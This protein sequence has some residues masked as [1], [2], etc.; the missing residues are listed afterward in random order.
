[1][2]TKADYSTEEWKAIAG[3]PMVAGLLITSADPGNP[4]GIAQQA[5]AVGN[6][7]KQSTLGDA[8]DIVKAVVEGVKSGNGRP[9]LP[10]IPAGDWSETNGALMTAIKSAVR[11]VERKS[12]SEVEAYKTWLAVVAAKVSWATKEVGVRGPLVKADEEVALEQLADVLKMVW[13]ASASRP[14]ARRTGSIARRAS[15][16][17]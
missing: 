8:P 7:I 16:H 11:T 10:D 1:M 2:S 15:Q 3:A 14:P 6:A 9:E 12:P 4:V 13:M 17:S 5:M